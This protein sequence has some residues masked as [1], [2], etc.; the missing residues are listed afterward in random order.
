MLKYSRTLQASARDANDARLIGESQKLVMNYVDVAYTFCEELASVPPG[1]RTA[2]FKRFGQIAT[3]R[4]EKAR[5]LPLRAHTARAGGEG[6]SSAA[7]SLQHFAGG[8]EDGFQIRMGPTGHAI[9]RCRV[10]IDDD[11]LA[12]APGSHFRQGGCRVHGQT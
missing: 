10:G 5:F 8:G 1:D 4:A 3:P 9:E 7:C 2:H 12:P 6:P 11:Q